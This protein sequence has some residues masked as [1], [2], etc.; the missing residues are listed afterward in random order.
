MEL[1]AYIEFI[2]QTVGGELTKISELNLK[3]NSIL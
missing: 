1:Q 3:A 2:F